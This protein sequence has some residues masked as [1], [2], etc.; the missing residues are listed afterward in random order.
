MIINK[1]PYTDFHEMNLDW[2]I[3]RIQNLEIDLEEVE[4]KATAAAFAKSKEYVDEELAKVVS[5][6]NALRAE[7]QHIQDVFNDT[8]AELRDD[9]TS[10]ASDVNNQIRLFDERLKALSK[11]IDDDIVGVNARTDLAIQ[12]NNEY[13][14]ET[15]SGNL[16]DVLLV[17]N[18]FTGDKISLQEMFNYLASLHVDDGIT[19]STLVERNK[20]F[21]ELVALDISYTN[22]V[23]H[24]NSLVV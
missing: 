3:E 13:I 22:L 6:F 24:G 15:I 21:D 11:K 14:F 16:T 8:I 7:F 23:L 4:A 1:Y 18:F 2:V 20:T 12:Q 9:Y 5:D 10:F 17:T 19:Y